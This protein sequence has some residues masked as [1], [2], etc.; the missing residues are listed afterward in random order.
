MCRTSAV[1]ISALFSSFCFIIVV[2]GQRPC[3]FN[4]SISC[5]PEKFFTARISVEVIRR[6]FGTNVTTLC[7]QVETWKS[8]VSRTTG[9]CDSDTSNPLR[10]SWNVVLEAYKYLCQE[11]R[12]NY[13]E[14]HKCMQQ[15]DFRGQSSTCQ[16]ILD[17]D[18]HNVHRRYARHT[19]G[20]Y[21]EAV[22][23][24]GKAAT[25]VCGTATGQVVERL[26]GILFNLLDPGHDC[27]TS[28]GRRMEN[29]FISGFI[30]STV[31]MLSFL[32]Q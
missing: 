7:G 14:H 24:V 23:C 20:S 12:T 6:V 15:S 2:E 32:Y 9:N 18:Q 19:C 10:K 5:F 28:S 29:G 16:T 26:T 31:V 8:C 3:N 1:L 17:K 13:N 25:K 27:R 4:D 21:H 11:I 22:N 30:L